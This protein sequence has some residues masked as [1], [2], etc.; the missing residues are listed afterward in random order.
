M[1]KVFVWGEC[2]V[3]SGGFMGEGDEAGERPPPMGGSRWGAGG[4]LP[5][6]RAPDLPTRLPCSH[7]FN[8]LVVPHAH[9]HHPMTHPHGK[10]I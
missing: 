9:V 5:A 2:A 7:Q 1:V 6:P 4:Q 10:K 8:V 3:I